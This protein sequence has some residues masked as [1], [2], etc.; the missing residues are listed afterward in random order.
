METVRQLGPAKRRATRPSR[1]CVHKVSYRGH[2]RMS[3]A[4]SLRMSSSTTE[5]WLRPTCVANV[6]RSVSRLGPAKRCV[7]SLGL[8]G[9]PGV[10]GKVWRAAL[11]GRGLSGPAGC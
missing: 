10:C 3:W 8:G 1:A 11:A 7:S 6:P 2:S 4:E 5:E 9:L